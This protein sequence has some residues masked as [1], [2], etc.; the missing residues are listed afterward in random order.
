MRQQID[1][2][3]L[4]QFANQPWFTD[5]LAKVRHDLNR[6]SFHD[7]DWEVQNLQDES[8]D[9]QSPL[10]ETNADY[11]PRV[12][13][14][15]RTD[16][17]ESVGLQS[18]LLLRAAVRLRRYDVLLLPV[19]VAT[20]AWTRRLLS[21][22][23]RGS[24]TPVVGVF[25]QIQSAGMVDL[26]ELGLADFVQTPIDAQELRARLL[27]AASRAPVRRSLQDSANRLPEKVTPVKS[28][29]RFL[30]FRV[31]NGKPVSFKEAK[32]SLI[33]AFE[34]EYVTDMLNMERGNVARAA[35]MSG[36]NRRAF[37]EI[38]RK[39]QISADIYRDGK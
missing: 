2:A 37:W 30:S 19:S 3:V 13:R 17:S 21:G 20:L 26:L 38:M 7:L 34:R 11:L 8:T 12:V 39:H 14:S 35:A 10:F 6:I 24:N 15:D 1:V 23:P 28:L 31:E 16:S 33:T 4:H 25:E 32:S 27:C 29:Q 5:A 9:L 22:I 18:D 36:K